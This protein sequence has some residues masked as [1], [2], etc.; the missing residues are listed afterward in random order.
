MKN[1]GRE[2]YADKF[3]GVTTW[4]AVRIIQKKNGIK[5]KTDDP[6]FTTSEVVNAVSIE[7]GEWINKN[8]ME[9]INKISKI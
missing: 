7:T 1:S 6:T 9:W 3:E 4:N 2:G 8:W 5:L